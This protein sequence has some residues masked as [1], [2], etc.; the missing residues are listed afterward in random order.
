MT[1]KGL[2]DVWKALPAYDWQPLA[3]GKAV[4]WESA[5][6]S[7]DMVVVGGGAVNIWLQSSEPDTDLQ[8]TVS[9]IRPDGQEVFVQNGWLRASYRKLDAKR[10]TPLY[11]IPSARDADVGP[12]PGG[13]WSKVSIPLYAQ[14]HA[15]RKGS[16]IRISIEAPGGDQPQWTFRT[17]TPKG[18]VTNRIA[19][20]PDM[21][22]G[23][24]LPVVKGA[25]IPA[26]LASACPGLRAEPCR[27]YVP[28]TNTP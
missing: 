18:T 8:A 25:K 12:L 17:L 21:P 15:Y 3:P 2:S 4:A 28:Y 14:G 27:T 23:V 5:P 19:M 9:E 10:S 1:E 26:P 13:E 24:V 20:G 7:E 11:P 16:R 22:S 6:L